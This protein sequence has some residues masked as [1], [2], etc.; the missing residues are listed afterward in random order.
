MDPMKKAMVLIPRY[1]SSLMA[2][3]SESSMSIKVRSYFQSG[4]PIRKSWQLEAQVTI[5]WI[6]GITT[7]SILRP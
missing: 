3:V 2:L 7:I 5:L 4:I 1:L 6:S